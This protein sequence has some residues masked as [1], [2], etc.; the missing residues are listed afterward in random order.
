MNKYHEF[1][2]QEK[3]EEVDYE[4]EEEVDYE[5]KEEVDYDDG[6][7][8]PNT[9]YE[10]G[11]IVEE[12]EIFEDVQSEPSGPVAEAVEHPRV[13][14]RDRYPAKDARRNHEYKHRRDR[15]LVK[16]DRRKYEY[17]PRRCQRR[18]HNNNN[19]VL[20]LLTS[21]PSKEKKWRKVFMRENCKIYDHVYPFRLAA[22]TVLRQDPPA[23]IQ[24]RNP[25]IERYAQF[26]CNQT[27]EFFGGRYI[28]DHF[29]EWYHKQPSSNSRVL[30][31]GLNSYN[32]QALNELSRMGAVIV[33][34]VNAHTADY[35]LQVDSDVLRVLHQARTSF[36][37]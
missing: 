29:L 20:V 15:Y 8:A 22:R 25:P 19:A 1:A 2:D 14:R 16:D 27:S 34:D 3:E 12:G 21:D 36:Y 9:S 35:F 28:T 11:E 7:F 37:V 23:R 26:L 5:E 33:S 32:V 31:C 4:E 17:R 18:K 13:E 24:S 6:N 10:D 30:I